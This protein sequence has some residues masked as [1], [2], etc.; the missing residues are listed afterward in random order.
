VE[1]AVERILSGQAGLALRLAAPRPML[2]EQEQW[3]TAPA[4][5][6]SPGLPC[7]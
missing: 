1:A 5:C 7:T 4:H 2:L 3:V 6:L